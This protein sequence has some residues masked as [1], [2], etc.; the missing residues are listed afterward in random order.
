MTRVITLVMAVP[1][2]LAAQQPAG[3][4]ARAIQ[5]D[6]AVRLA[7]RNN[8]AAV[9]ARNALR[10]STAAVRT[11]YAQYIPSLTASASSQN[12]H[13]LR[14]CPHKYSTSPELLRLSESIGKLSSSRHMA[15]A[16]V[17]A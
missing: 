1:F 7:Q 10:T 8:P 6:E 17:S 15:R 11:A 12:A 16:S 9:Q 3:D 13:A 4:G 14:K 2:A 5:L